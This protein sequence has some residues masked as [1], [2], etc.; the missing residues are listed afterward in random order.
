MSF[1]I[2]YLL[3]RFVYQ[4]YRSLHDWYIGSLISIWHATISVFERMDQVLAFAV[5][6]RHLFEPLYQDETILG[7]I[8]GLIFRFSRALIGAVVYATLFAFALIIYLLWALVP[9]YIVMWGLGRI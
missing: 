1:S 2:A 4:V 5:N 9:I 8:L 6:V 3:Q 7:R